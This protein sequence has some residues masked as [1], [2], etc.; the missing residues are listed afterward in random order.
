MMDLCESPRQPVPL[1]QITW[2]R[3]PII[4]CSFFS[5]LSDWMKFETDWQRLAGP[6]YSYTFHVELTSAHRV[7]ARQ[8]I[9]LHLNIWAGWNAPTIKFDPL[10]RKKTKPLGFRTHRGSDDIL[11]WLKLLFLSS[12][13]SNLNI[14]DGAIGWLASRKVDYRAIGSNNR[15]SALEIWILLSSL[16][17]WMT[18][19]GWNFLSR[20]IM[21]SSNDDDCLLLMIRVGRK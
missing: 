14:R 16:K 3:R 2:K 19:E 11:F 9:L 15:T 10:P 5:G 20:L 4:A 21:F 7:L 1:V 6:T 18:Q 8:S 13:A 12:F 17:W